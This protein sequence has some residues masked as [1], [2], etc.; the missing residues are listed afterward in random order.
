MDSLDFCKKRAEISPDLQ[1]RTFDDVGVFDTAGL[2]ENLF[3][4]ISAYKQYTVTGLDSMGNDLERHVTLDYQKDAD[5]EYC[6]SL[7]SIHEGTML[8]V[9]ET[10]AKCLQRFL[11]GDTYNVNKRPPDGKCNV[12]YTIGD[13]IVINE[14]DLEHKKFAKDFR[15]MRT[16]VMIPLIYEYEEII[17]GEENE[18]ERM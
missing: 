11:S 18:A 10:V 12:K 5:W 8:F 16:T 9:Q 14:Y 6:T 2:V 7:T 13:T 1:D 15:T 4:R 17:D 3:E